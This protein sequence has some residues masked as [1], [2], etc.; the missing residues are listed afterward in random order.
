MYIF[1]INSYKNNKLSKKTIKMKKIFAIIMI[2]ATMLIAYSCGCNRENNENE[3]VNE[4]EVV[5]LPQPDS[6]FVADTLNIVE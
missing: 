3:C 6:T 5:S 2:A 4:E 1:G